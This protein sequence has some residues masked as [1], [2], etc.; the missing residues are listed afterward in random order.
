MLRIIFEL[1]YG[2]RVKDTMSYEKALALESLYKSRGIN[3]ICIV[4]FN[5]KIIKNKCVHFSEHRE[6]IDDFLFDESY[7]G[8]H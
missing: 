1:P 7:T 8:Y 5:N 2:Y 3:V 6:I 4:D